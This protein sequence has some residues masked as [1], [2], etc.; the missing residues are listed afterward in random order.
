MVANK[1]RQD[2]LPDDH[3]AVPLASSSPSEVTALREDCLARL[4]VISARVQQMSTQASADWGRAVNEAQVGAQMRQQSL[5]NDYMGKVQQASVR[6]ESMKEL[7]E[8]SAQCSGD[9]E[10]S[11]EDARKAVDELRE[12]LRAAMDS[13]MQD[14]NREWDATCMGFVD[15]VRHQL[16]KLDPASVEP[17][18]LA[19]AG[20][21]LTWIASLMRPPAA[22]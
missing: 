10:L 18:A 19:A 4:K 3:A 16:S 21:S 11:R 12:K 9:F 15:A 1:G 22:R 20:Q 5:F 17:A 8:L 2:S 6:A 7:H 14:A 13:G